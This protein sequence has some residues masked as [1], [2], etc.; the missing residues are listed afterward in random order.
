MTE[1][2][3]RRVVLVQAH[4]AGASTPVWTDDDRAW[5]TR[6]AR[7]DAQGGQTFDRFV[8]ARARHAL[9]RLLPRDASARRWL[10]WRAWR[11]LWPLA[12]GLLAF[13]LGVAIDHIGASQRVDVLAP[14]VWAVVAWNLAVYVSLLLPHSA[15]RVRRALARFWQGGPAGVRA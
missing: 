11:P 2:E 4:E 13:V 8:V 6:A 7:Q 1:D 14:P 9:E 15:P 10:A 12:A 3:A 5:A